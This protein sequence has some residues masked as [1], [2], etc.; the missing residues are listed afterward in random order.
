[1]LEGL[2]MLMD[3]AY[4]GDE[5]RQLVLDLGM[6]PVVPPKS[7]RLYPWDYD[8]A[9][10]KKRNRSSDC[11]A[12]SKASAESSHALKNPTSSFR[13]SIHLHSWLKRFA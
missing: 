12:N 1:M 4:E 11:S 10:Y 8:H 13:R 2:P 9:I 7:N 5:S 3:R 6:I